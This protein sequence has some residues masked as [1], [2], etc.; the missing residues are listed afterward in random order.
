MGHKRGKNAWP[1]LISSWVIESVEMNSMFK[2]LLALLS[3]IVVALI[4]FALTRATK[5]V[6]A[7]TI[8]VMNTNDSGAGSL[9]QA[10]TD[11][12]SGDTIDFGVTGIRSCA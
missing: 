12:G 11:A 7:A 4:G 9:R 3:V 1:N 8:T 6:S 2:R 5:H 10:I